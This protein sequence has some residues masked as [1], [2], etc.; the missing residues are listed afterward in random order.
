M[1]NKEKKINLVTGGAGFIGSHLVRKLLEKG[2]FVICQDN[3]LTG[4]PINILNFRKLKN[5]KV[6]NSSVLDEIDFDVDYIWHLASPASP[7][8]YYKNPIETTKIIIE[9]TLNLLDLAK[10][11]NAKLLY[12]SSS[13]IYG[14]VRKLPIEENDYSILRS[15]CERNCYADSKKLAETLCRDYKRVFSLDIRIARIFNTY[16]P[17][18]SIDDGRVV[19]SFIYN[20][21]NNLPLIVNGDG[22]QTRSFCFVDDLVNG[23]ILLM[24]S[25]FIEPLNLGFPEE[26]RIIDLAKI[27]K[28]RTNSE[29]E[30][31]V[32]KNVLNEPIRR[33][34][35]IEMAKKH[36]N[37]NPSVSLVEGID[38][39][40]NCMKNK[41]DRYA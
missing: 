38:S 27:I 33:L 3:Y 32:R 25:N 30:I 22:M 1:N 8:F 36:L 21:I 29:S 34:P 23:L 9:G 4:S 18:M 37:W 13:E 7:K 40:V 39:T 41:L 19:N 31:V 24:N 28:E 20:S 35:S 14:N 10:N 12:A 11:K 26:T 17:N 15:S 2:E 6:I 5:F 16:G